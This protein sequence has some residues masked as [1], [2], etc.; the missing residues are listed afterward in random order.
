MCQDHGLCGEARFYAISLCFASCCCYHLS[1]CLSV[2]IESAQF[3]LLLLLHLVPCGFASF[4]A[5]TS[6]A[7]FRGFFFLFLIHPAIWPSSS[8]S[9]WPM[10]SDI[11]D[12]ASPRSP[13][14]NFKTA[15]WYIY[16]PNLT[17]I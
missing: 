17:P 5:F 6:C 7:P 13:A 16:Q 1:V 8:D 11:R 9:V 14:L 4:V 15:V 2:V 3:F 12:S 10:K